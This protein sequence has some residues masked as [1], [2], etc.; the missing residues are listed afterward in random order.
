M[1]QEEDNL[2]VESYLRGNLETE[3]RRRVELR[4]EQDE[5]F[6]KLLADE[7]LM[8]SGLESAGRLKLKESMSQWEQNHKPG[9]PIKVIQWRS[10]AVMGLAA[11]LLIAASYFI[12]TTNS[13]ADTSALFAEYYQ[14]YPNIIMP[15][16]RGTQRDSSVLA[17]AFN[18]YDNLQYAEA[19]T[20]FEAIG[21]KDGSVYFY[22]GLAHLAQSDIERAIVNLQQSV[23]IDQ[24]FREQAEWYLALSYLRSDRL[25]KCAEMLSGIELRGGSYAK[26]AREL[27]EKLN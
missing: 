23:H 22:L 16:L 6:R 10:W 7:A 24:A 20:R 18:A 21:N 25:K 4:A 5:D 11:S 17:Y 19:I 2:L 8:F 9:S 14:Q 3:A 1:K 26:R 15:S 12:W 13:T 27:Q